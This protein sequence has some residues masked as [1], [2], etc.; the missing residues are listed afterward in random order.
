MTDDREEAGSAMSGGVRE[1]FHS[2]TFV[3]GG[4]QTQRWQKIKAGD[5]APGG[6]TAVLLD[7]ADYAEWLRCYESMKQRLTAVIDY[8]IPDTTPKPLDPQ[9]VPGLPPVESFCRL[10]GA[11]RTTDCGQ[12]GC[13]NRGI[14]SFPALALRGGD[15]TPR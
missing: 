12:T 1:E 8:Y 13:P 11:G 7:A 10:C 14:A 15:G 9:M 3:S 5:A 6:A 4:V 2:M